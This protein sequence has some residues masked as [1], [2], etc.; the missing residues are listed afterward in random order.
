VPGPSTAGLPGGARAHL[1]TRVRTLLGSTSTNYTDDQVRQYLDENQ[2]P[3]DTFARLLAWTQGVSN[4][5]AVYTTP[6]GNWDEGWTTNPVLPGTATAD[7]VAGRWTITNPDTTWVPPDTFRLQGVVYDVYGTAADALQR[8]ATSRVVSFTTTGGETLT[9]APTSH[10]VAE[11]R[12]RA[13]AASV[14]LDRGDLAGDDVWPGRW[15]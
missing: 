6:V 3:A 13:W 12:G 9:T 14:I 2:R 10:L 5:V 4:V 8:D 7:L 11:Y 1:V 15:S